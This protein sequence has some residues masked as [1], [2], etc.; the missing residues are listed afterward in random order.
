MMNGRFISIERVIE[1]VYRDYAFDTQLD[2][3]DALEW[4]GECLDLIGAPATYIEKMSD[5]KSE[6]NHPCP[7][8]IK[9]YRGEIPCDVLHL[10][11]AFLKGSSTVGTNSNDNLIP[12][13]RSTDS[14]HIGKYKNNSPDLNR[15]DSNYTYKLNNNYIF[16][17]FKE[18]EVVI[19]YDANPTDEKGFPLIPDNVKYIKACKSYVASKLAFRLAIQNK[20]NGDILNRIEQDYYFNVA[21]AMVAGR[22]PNIDEMESWKNNFLKLTPDINSHSSAFRGDGIMEKRFNNSSSI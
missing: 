12:M 8:V 22:I 6:L 16:T 17:S 10:K 2:W 21:Q 19:V 11:Q 15:L 18:G 3:I 20:M 7:I 13:R 14:L 4:I 1:G 9:D 5:G